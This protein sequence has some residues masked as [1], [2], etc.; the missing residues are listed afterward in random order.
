MKAAYYK[1]EEIKK[2]LNEKLAFSL[3]KKVFW[4]ISQKKTAMPP[5]I[6]LNLPRLS[7]GAPGDFRAM[8]AYIGGMGN[9]VCGIKWVS[10]F[11]SNPRLNLPTVI[12]TILLNSEKTGALLAIFEGN[13]ITAM[14]T[15]AAAAVA[16]HTLANPKPH[17]LSIIGAG[18]QA[19]YQLHAMTN[20]YAFDEIGVWGF[21]K[22]ESRRF[23]KRLS[24]EHL[25]LRP[26]EDIK[27]CVL[28]ADIIVT[29]TPS[30][31]PLLKKEWVKKGAHINAMGADAKGKEELNS[32]LLLGS[33]IVVDE[34]QQA[35]HSGEIN[36]PLSNKI[37]SRKNVYGELSEII[38]GKKKGRVSPDEI[39]IFDS[40][41]LAVLDI[42]FANHLATLFSG[43]KK[44]C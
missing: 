13:H 24:G 20:L 18:F 44:T 37:L 9:G 42:Y 28:S 34:W 39:T 12:A 38:S 19:E 17:K 31:R 36:V 10:V 2:V 21:V 6:Y 30:R 1:E 15:G 25:S 43:C 8:P 14:R 22:G 29:C 11:P 26:Y 33:K 7:K 5:K 27:S 35:S 41:G 23:C 32:K 16:T 40:T 4:L 3:A